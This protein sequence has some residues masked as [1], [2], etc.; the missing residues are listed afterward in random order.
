MNVFKRIPTISA[1]ELENKLDEKPLIIDVRTT[2]EFQMGHIKGA[3][4]VP[5][6][7]VSTH[8]PREKAY[9]ICQSGSRS[10]RASKILDKNGFEVVNVKGG[11]RKWNGPTR[12]GKY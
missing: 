5:L 1:K 3:K 4:N 2:A 11:M 8:K 12:G 9:I 10:K 6:D 7:K